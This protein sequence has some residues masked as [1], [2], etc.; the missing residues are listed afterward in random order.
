ML[1]YH[2][3]RNFAIILLNIKAKTKKKESKINFLVKKY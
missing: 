1:D 3:Y 2:S